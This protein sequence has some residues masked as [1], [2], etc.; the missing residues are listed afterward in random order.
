MSRNSNNSGIFFQPNAFYP[1]RPAGFRT[2]ASWKVKTSDFNESTSD[3]WN[4]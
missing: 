2:N 3:L 4:Q 1:K